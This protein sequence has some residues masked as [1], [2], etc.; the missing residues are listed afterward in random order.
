MKISLRPLIVALSVL[1]FLA[2]GG[3]GGGSNGGS[4]FFVRD[5]S[6]SVAG[7]TPVEISEAFFAFLADE[8]TTGPGGTDM[9]MDGDLIDAICIVINTINVEEIILPVAVKEFEWV[10]ADLFLV[11][12]EALDSTDWDGDMATTSEVLLHWEQG[13][14]TPEFVATISTTASPQILGAGSVRLYYHNATTPVGP[15]MTNLFYVDI[16]APTTPVPVMS[17]DATAELTVTML[18]EEGGLLSCSLDET[19]EGRDLNNDVDS[20]DTA[21]LAL[22]DATDPAGIL[23]STALAFSSSATPRAMSTAVSDW[24]VAFLVDEAAQGATNLNDPVLFSPTWEPVQCDGFEDADAADAVLHFLD[25]ADWNMNPGLN[26]PVNTGLVGT[27]RIVMAPGTEGFIGT[28]SLESDEGT[29]DLNGDGDTTDRIF[30]YVRASSPI[31]PPTSA[32]NL[33]AIADM[34]P[35]GVHGMVPLDGRFVVL[36]DEAADGRD[37]NNDPGNDF[38]ILA[39]VAPDESNLDVAFVFDH[40]GSAT[41][42][43][44]GATWM[45]EIP[46]NSRMVAAIPESVGGGDFNDDLDVID[47]VPAFPDFVGGPR[48]NFPGATIAVVEDNA[49]SVIV[50]GTTFFRV[51]EAADSRDWNN[52]GDAADIVLLRLFESTGS[53]VFVSVLNDLPRPA[54]EFST[55]EAFPEVGVFVIDEAMAGID[56]NDDG[57]VSD[58]VVRYF[59]F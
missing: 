2:L 31:L 17:T 58:R 41:P 3:C 53:P 8:A 24:L 14:T 47:S 43:F 4:S 42:V 46:G 25:F 37:H 57:D 40:S 52:D 13:L 11:V 39:W 7:T 54:A 12:D 26:P 10:G 51:D 22:L 35:G 45:D 34:V 18:S 16:G 1:P 38:D 49:G 27:T 33:H 21:V 44:F 19:V 48:L 23:R 6:V 36:V 50:N 56:A 29:C 9:N 15:F 59:R 32:A 20:T 28:L 30:R 55:T 5:T